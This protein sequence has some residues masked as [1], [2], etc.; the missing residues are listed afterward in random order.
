MLQTCLIDIVKTFNKNTVK[1]HLNHFRANFTERFDIYFSQCIKCPERLWPWW[2]CVFCVVLCVLCVLQDVSHKFVIAVLMEYIRSL[3]QFQITVQVKTLALNIFV[4]TWRMF[5]LMTSS[6][7][8]C[9]FLCSGSITCTSW[10]LRRWCSTTSSTCC[11]SSCSITSSVTPNRWWVH[12]WSCSRTRWL[13]ILDLNW[14]WLF[15]LE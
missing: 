10:W 4:L 1:Y 12:T 2:F 8:D 7:W 15:L 6:P 13:W 3:N 5:T 14:F 9:V 11:T